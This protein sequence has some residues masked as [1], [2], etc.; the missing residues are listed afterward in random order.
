M[1]P[2]EHETHALVRAMQ[3]RMGPGKQFDREEE[4]SMKLKGWLLAATGQPALPRA[5][6]GWSWN[7]VAMREEKVICN[8]FPQGREEEAT[9]TCAPLLL[10]ALN[11]DESADP[12]CRVYLPGE[13]GSGGEGLCFLGSLGK[14]QSA[15]WLF[16]ALLCKGQGEQCDALLGEIKLGAVSK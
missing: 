3:R 4:H 8:A 11:C 13:R 1:D 16:G 6:V 5:R 9:R 12:Q 15:V 14:P 7:G 2:V 10:A